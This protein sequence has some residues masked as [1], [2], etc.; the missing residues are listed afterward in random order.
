[1]RSGRMFRNVM[2]TKNDIGF[3]HL[4]NDYELISERLNQFTIDA[5][6][7]NCGCCISSRN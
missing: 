3:R 7:G 1:M 6:V 4:L 2:R 5:F